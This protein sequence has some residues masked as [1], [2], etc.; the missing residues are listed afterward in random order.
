MTEEEK[1]TEGD[2]LLDIGTSTRDNE[3]G[4][5][6]VKLQVDGIPSKKVADGIVEWLENLVSR[7]LKRVEQFLA[8]K[9]GKLQ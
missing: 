9:R 2:G 6:S 4:T 3:D 1:R 7:D 8:A 5:W